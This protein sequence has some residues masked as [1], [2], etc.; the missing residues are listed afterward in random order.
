LSA[1]WRLL[2]DSAANNELPDTSRDSDE[3]TVTSQDALERVAANY[4]ICHENSTTLSSLQDWVKEQ[5]LIK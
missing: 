3:R 2:H 1:G 5:S 4:G